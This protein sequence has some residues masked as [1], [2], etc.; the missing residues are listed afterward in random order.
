MIMDTIADAVGLH[1]GR[2]HTV[3]VE[4]ISIAMTEITGMI[5]IQISYSAPVGGGM[6][7]LP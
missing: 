6:I 1:P 2:Q 5:G 4:S 7:M 3:I